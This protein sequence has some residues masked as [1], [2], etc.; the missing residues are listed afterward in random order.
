MRVMKRAEFLQQPAGTIYS[1][2]PPWGFMSLEIKSETWDNDW[3]CLNPC[4]VDADSSEESMGRLE[5]MLANG[6]SYPGT[7]A[8]GRDGFFDGEDVVFLVF[9]RADL[10]A[11]QEHIAGALAV[12][13]T[14]QD[15][16]AAESNCSRHDSTGRPLGLYGV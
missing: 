15:S 7:Q 6:T 9:E 2:A 14:Q 1:K 11:L 8:F 12:T 10:E 4:W 5:D 3:V 16:C 13:P